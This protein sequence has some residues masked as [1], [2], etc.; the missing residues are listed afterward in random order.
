M[1]RKF[2]HGL[3]L[4][5]VVLMCFG[6]LGCGDSGNDGQKKEHAS[7]GGENTEAL[8]NG[9][10]M[11]TVVSIEGAYYYDLFADDA[12]VIYALTDNASESV[13]KDANVIAW[14][15]SNQGNTWEELLYQPDT[16]QEGSELE[17]GALR[18]SEG[19]IEA[20]AIFS[21]HA[22]EAGEEHARRLYRIT[23][24]S[25]DELEASE[26]FNQLGDEA[27]WN[28][29]F[30]NGHVIS[31]AGGE[32]CVLYDIDQ[33]KAVKNLSYDSFAA[34]F[35]SMQE[36]F[37]VY[38]KEIVYCLDAETLEEQEPEKSLQEF[39]AAMYE[40][41]DGVVFPP[42]DVYKDTVV[43]ATTEAIY[44]YREGKTV[45]ALSIPDIVNLGQSFN[46]M[47]PLCKGKGNAYYVG[48]FA[49][50]KMNLQQIVED[51]ETEKDAFT[52][53]SL[54]KNADIAQIA[55]LFQQEH[56]E[57]KVE[58]E[59]GMEGEASL[60]RTDAIKQLNTELLAGGGP[61]I[62]IMDGLSVERY[63][64]TELLLPIELERPED[65]YFKNIIE[66]YQKD[67]TLYAVPIGFWLYAV[68]G[69]TDMASEIA[70]PT[71]L[72][73]WILA[74][75]DKAGL[76]GYEYSY[77]YNTYS[78]YTQFI[79][80]A[81][82]NHIV[83]NGTVNKE[84]LDAYM[85][86]CKRLA[87]TSASGFIEEDHI[88]YTILPGMVEIHYNDNI[89]VSAGM[90]VAASNLAA[91]VTEQENEVAEYSLYP[92]YQPCD[93]VAIN[94]NTE[95]AGI[96][97]NFAEFSLGE[98]V[99][100]MSIHSLLPVSLESFHNV[101]EG[102]GMEAD[103]DGLLE[104]IT[105][106]GEESFLIYYLSKDET[107]S[108]EQEIKEI[109]NVFTDDVLVRDIVMEA[110]GSYLSGAVSLEEAVSSAEN[111]ANLYLGE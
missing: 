10:G 44:E 3:V 8:E 109:N 55:M 69:S 19:G 95:H 105:L 102:E 99:Q 50:G 46:G 40:K 89:K 12:G 111:K 101:M 2:Y 77:G 76:G 100:R 73:Q 85:G 63:A 65:K 91:L 4:I 64:D 13:L 66:T 54:V 32:Q 61:D 14:K 25:C 93:I 87:E 34:A 74:N 75:A 53:Y 72:C 16:L 30:V 52:I 17:A 103:S 97:Q 104:E 35:L 43:C 78:Q 26:A 47:L 90:V 71:D 86:I 33:Q 9:K 22:D 18:A 42:M 80:D 88:T 15:S 83:Q 7:A 41:N 92:M 37:L 39:V 81:Y 110:L 27:L 59:V 70:T 23:E 29:S 62:I 56:P 49:S 84:A 107:D 28:V 57:L 38:G 11:S 106:S 51:K 21:E 48:V 31:I 67:N 98:S 94:A 96:A 82:A 36:Q 1:K 58:V 24:N 45:Q 79:Y 20:F 68:Q 6:I 108:L 5:S 60:T